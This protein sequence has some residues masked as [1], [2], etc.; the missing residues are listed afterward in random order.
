MPYKHWCSQQGVC[1]LEIGYKVCVCAVLRAAVRLARR[2][3]AQLG[4]WWMMPSMR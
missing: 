4:L 2:L 3:T 1:L